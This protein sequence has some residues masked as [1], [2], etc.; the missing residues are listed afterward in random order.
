MHD[1]HRT[2]QRRVVGEG[3]DEAVARQRSVERQHRIGI[4]SR[5]GLQQARV[6]RERRTKRLD[7]K[8]AFK[9]RQIG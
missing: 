2:R 4:V 7:R 1:V 5:L 9:P 6:L 3:Y 8:P